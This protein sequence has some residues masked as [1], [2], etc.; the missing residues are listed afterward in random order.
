MKILRSRLRK[1]IKEE[2]DRWYL[3]KKKIAKYAREVAIKRQDRELEAL[4]HALEMSLNN[5]IV[6]AKGSP[7]YGF[8]TK[9]IEDRIAEKLFS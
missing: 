3:K 6:M 9:K 7:F 2:I 1:I 8:T 4:A 5:G